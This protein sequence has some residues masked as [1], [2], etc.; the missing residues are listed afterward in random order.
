MENT[1]EMNE[2]IKKIKCGVLSKFP[3]LGAVVSNMKFIS[4]DVNTAQTDGNNIYF[5]KKFMDSLTYKE[6]LAVF[7]HEIMHV[8][9]DHILRSKD[10]DMYTWN[11]ATDAVINQM[12]KAEDLPLP[13]GCVDM[14]DAKNKSAEEM[15]TKLIQ[16]KEFK[17]NNR[18]NDNNEDDNS[19]SGGFDSHSNWGDIVK[20]IERSKG[21]QGNIENSKI[22]EKNFTKTNDELKK[23]ISSEFNN[24]LKKQNEDKDNY[25]SERY[26]SQMENVTKP[27]VSWKKLLKKELDIEEDRWS[28]RRADENNYYSARIESQDVLDKPIIE[29]ILDV[30]GS[31]DE[32]LLRA[33][34]IE[35]THLIKDAELKVGT[36]ANDF[37]GW[38]KVKTK[39]DIKNLDLDYYGGTNYDCAVRA[40]SKGKKVNK[41]IFTDGYEGYMPSDD[42]KEEKI[43]WVVFKNKN[44]MPCCGKV[45]YVDKNK[46]MGEDNSK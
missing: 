34:L 32:N 4:S 22:L 2:Y 18:N 37:N 28:Y 1:Q 41:I 19:S 26:L 16:E 30:S 20:K 11:I 24:N 40:F 21:G 13:K 36:F 14:L 6:N 42:L 45:V 8:A 17:Q 29:V 5:N 35:L 44:F 27:A 23:D 39:K 43:L 10:K 15:Y 31:I 12:L 3:L 7:A 46:I 33:F 9:F 25:S 38:N